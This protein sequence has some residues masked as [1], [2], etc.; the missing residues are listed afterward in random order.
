MPILTTVHDAQ[1]LANPPRDNNDLP[2]TSVVTLTKTIRVEN[3]P[4]APDGI[5]WSRLTEADLDEMP[6]SKDLAPTT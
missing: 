1:V 5:D 2:L 4:P 3:S 6:V